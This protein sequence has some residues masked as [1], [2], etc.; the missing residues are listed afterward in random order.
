MKIIQWAFPYLPTMGGREIFVQRLSQSLAGQGHDIHVIAPPPAKNEL[1]DPNYVHLDKFPVHRHD[2]R[3]AMLAKDSVKVEATQQRLI[4]DL[5]RIQPDVIHVHTIGPEIVVLRDALRQ[6]KIDAKFVYTHHGLS[7][8]H[9]FWRYSLSMV[10][11]VV[12]ISEHSRNQILQLVP[13]I[14]TKLIVI[15]N[16]VPVTPQY[17]P[18][19][20]SQQ[21]IFAFGR[22]SAEKGFHLLLEAWAAVQSNTRGLQLVI[23]GEGVDGRSL[24]AQSE[25]L[26]ITATVSFPGWL[27]QA[28]IS[29]KLVDSRL[30]VVPSTFEEPFGL[31][32]AEAHAKARPVIASRIG[33]LPEI[34]IDGETGF[35][36]E[37]SS[38]QT[39]TAALV[40][41]MHDI[42]QLQSMGEKAHTRAINELNWDSCVREYEML[43]KRLVVS[44]G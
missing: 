16:G 44:R 23:A 12:A 9:T 27:N 41:V 38:S 43:F 5:T 37:P 29:Q 34:V 19:G 6:A 15:R 22:L 28:Q 1:T 18:L 14:A 31:V 25:K 21:E 10:D 35:L 39:L 32:A 26:G 30:V 17:T 2:L 36:V 8:D 20:V 3:K 13:F 42:P 7:E 24:R 33:G 4:L 40:G 11:A